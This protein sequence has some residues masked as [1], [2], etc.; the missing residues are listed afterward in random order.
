MQRAVGSTYSRSG[1]LCSCR[2]PSPHTRTGR[3]PS[4]HSSPLFAMFQVG[5]TH[6][7]SGCLAFSLH[8]SSHLSIHTSQIL[9]KDSWTEFISRPYTPMYTSPLLHKSNH[10]Y[11]H[12]CTHTAVSTSPFHT[13][14]HASP[15]TP[16]RFSRA[17]RGPRSSRGG[18]SRLPLAGRLAAPYTSSRL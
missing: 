16:R 11:S 5:G 7:A 4:D 12:T 18:C 15:F 17:T 8:L 2:H 14:V 1:C 9:T 3:G 10:T 13:T 6:S